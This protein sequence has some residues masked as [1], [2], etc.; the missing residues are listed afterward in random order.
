MTKIKSN[1]YLISIRILNAS[2]SGFIDCEEDDDCVDYM[3]SPI[4][5]AGYVKFQVES[6]SGKFKYKYKWENGMCTK[7]CEEDD[8]CRPVGL[9][10]QKTPKKLGKGI[11]Q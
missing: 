4:C 10:C 5:S 8:D 6:S 9:T 2:F 1:Y 3:F 7:Y 11:C